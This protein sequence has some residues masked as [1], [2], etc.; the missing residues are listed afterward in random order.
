MRYKDIHPTLRTFMGAH[1][2]F[3]KLGF[4]P[5]DVYL[6]LAKSMLRGGVLSC[7]ATLRAQGTEFTI[8]CG[9]VPDG[10]RGAEAFLNEYKKVVVAI[11]DGTLPQA[12]LDRVWQESYCHQKAFEFSAALLRKGFRFPSAEN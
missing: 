9:D 8:E 1:E 2:G 10:E 4:R 11:N 7:F 12:D 5:D 6:Q 3:R